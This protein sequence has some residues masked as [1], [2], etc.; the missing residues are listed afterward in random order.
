[1]EGKEHDVHVRSKTYRCFLGGG[2]ER[3]M[4]GS[5][6]VVSRFMRLRCCGFN[7]AAR[8]VLRASTK[9]ID[10]LMSFTYM[11]LCS[12]LYFTVCF[13]CSL[14]IEALKTLCCGIWY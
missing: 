11:A 13:V 9:G 2:R 14:K 5:W 1:M 8:V 10:V 3:G 12:N 7:S 4:G 6:L